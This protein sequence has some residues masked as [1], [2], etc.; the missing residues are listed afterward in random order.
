MSENIVLVD[1]GSANGLYTPFK[2]IRK[3]EKNVIIYTF[4]PEKT[5]F[6]NNIDKDNINFNL[7]LYNDKVLGK[8]YITKKKECSSL[9]EPNMELMSK[10]ENPQRF[11]V[12]EIIDVELERLD[13]I[14]KK[15]VDIIK[16]DTQGSEYEI[17]E[18]C[19]NLL[20][21]VKIIVIEVEFDKIYLDQKLF[22]DLYYF[23]KNKNFKLIKFLRLVYFSTDKSYEYSSKIEEEIK[24]I[25]KSSNLDDLGNLYNVKFLITRS[26]LKNNIN[27][28]QNFYKLIELEKKI[29]NKIPDFLKNRY[30]KLFNCDLL[31]G[32]AVFV[33]QNNEY[34][35]LLNYIN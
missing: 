28:I 22:M 30:P 31:F 2:K 35:M 33:N 15:N 27:N 34:N 9:F 11:K 20:T 24:K 23:L 32:D 21:D 5:G 29:K 17:L 8:L 18:G 13:S 4:D 26:L 3:N 7:G 16:L 25:C 14:V 6:Q 1:V 10:Y 12:V 19:G